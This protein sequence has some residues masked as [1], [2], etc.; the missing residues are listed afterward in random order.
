MSFLFI[1]CNQHQLGQMLSDYS[2]S[3]WP[4]GL[5]CLDDAVPIGHACMYLDNVLH[6][7]EI[8]PQ[9]FKCECV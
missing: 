9:L 7:L 1:V 6:I 5:F 4:H 8:T 3:P 2:S